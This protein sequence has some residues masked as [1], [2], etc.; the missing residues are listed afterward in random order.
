M[1]LFTTKIY[2]E[3][4]PKQSLA[5]CLKNRKFVKETVLPAIFPNKPQVTSYLT[6]S[7]NG[8]Y[9]WTP[10]G[11]TG[12]VSSNVSS[13]GD[14]ITN[15]SITS[16]K[17]A[18]T[19]VGSGSYIA[20]NITIDS[21]G[22]ISDATSNISIVYK[23]PVSNTDR[24]VPVFDGTDTYNIL[25]TQVIIDSSD[26]LIAPSTEQA[27]DT[28]SGSVRTMGGLA[29][30]KDIRSD[31]NIFCYDVITFSDERLK[32]DIK[33]LHA[34][35][36]LSLYQFYEYSLIKNPSKRKE[37]G[38]IAQKLQKKHPEIVYQN[39]DGTLG[40]DYRSLHSLLLSDI[41]Q[42]MSLL[43]DLSKLEKLINKIDKLENEVKTLKEKIKGYD[44]YILKKTPSVNVNHCRLNILNK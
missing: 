3:T 14:T 1:S 23:N 39:R 31:G 28:N 22:L 36:D 37:Y 17:L 44:L 41:T 25:G 7:A 21:K 40:V 2:D 30:K 15:N 27:I 9:S 33:P 16:N 12:I 24:S 11:E 43:P 19:G 4:D 8:E 6:Q 42:K 13:T 10:V 38:V 26:R 32:R 29:V 35:L 34:D 5:V 18:D 20:P